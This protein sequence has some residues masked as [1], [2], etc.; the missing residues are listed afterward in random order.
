MTQR[1]CKRLWQTV[2]IKNDGKVMTQIDDIYDDN[3]QWQ[4]AKKKYLTQRNETRDVTKLRHKV[5]TQSDD[6]K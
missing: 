3:K 1:V 5:M 4:N 2:F 6:I